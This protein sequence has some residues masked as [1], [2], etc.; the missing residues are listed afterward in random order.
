MRIYVRAEDIKYGKPNMACLCPI[1]RA[2]RR[3][4]NLDEDDVRVRPSNVWA[5]GKSYRL[6]DSGITFVKKFDTGKK[7]KPFKVTLTEMPDAE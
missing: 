4:L 1:A 7:V 6:S 5:G 3:S 2:I